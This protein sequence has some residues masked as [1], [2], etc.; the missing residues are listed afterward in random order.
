MYPLRRIPFWPWLVGGVILAGGLEGATAVESAATGQ[1]HQKIQPLL[2]QYCYQCHGDGAHKGN[3]AFD[4]LKSNDEILNHDLWSKVMVNI[5]AGLMPP[6]T[7][8]RPS[9]AEQKLLEDWVKHQAF[10]IDS[11]NPD[12]GRVTLRR[13]N[14]VQYQNTIHDL[15]GVDFNAGEEFPPDDTGYGF[16]DIGD[17]LTISPM[18]LE[19]YMAAATTIVNEGVP[20]VA[21]VISQTRMAGSRFQGPGYTPPARA[22]G[23]GGNPGPGDTF[24][25]IPFYKGGTVTN[26]FEVKHAGHYELALEVT[27]KGTFNFDPGKCRVVLKADGKELS[28]RDFT[29]ENT[30]TFPVMKFEQ[31]WEPGPHP[32]SFEVQPLTPADQQIQDLLEMRLDYVEVSGPSDERYLSRPKNFDRFFTRDAPE[33]PRARRLYARE[34]LGKFAYKAFRR[35]VDGQTVERLVRLAE[36]VYQLPGKTFE[37]G[38]GQAMVAVLA[39]P[40]FLFLNEEAD[41][42][43]AKETYPLVDEYALA[44][45][46]SYFLWCPMPDDD[47]LRLAATGGLR[48]H[49]ASQVTRML[50]DPR[51]EA[52]VNN[53]TGQWLQARD[54]ETMTID[55]RT[56]LARDKGTEKAPRG[57]GGNAGN[58][59]PAF[60]LNADTKQAMER[61]TQMVFSSIMHEDRSLTELLEGNYT[62]LNETLAKA[63]GLTNLNVN[64]KEMRRVVLPPDSARGGVLTEGT[65]LVVTSNPDR[66][67]PVKRG[68]FV[69]NN[70]LGSPP[71]PPPPNIPALEVAEKD[72]HDHPPTLRE[73]LA[74][75]RE[76]PECSACHSRMD[77]LGLAFENFNALGLWRDAERSQP[78]EAGGQLI[79]G[80]KFQSVRELKHILATNH[81]E[82]FYRTLA[83]K[84]MTFATGRGMEYYDTETVDQ[85]VDRM[86][87]EDGRFSALLTG[88]IESA[89]FQKERSQAN[90]T[91]SNPPQNSTPK[92][93]AANR[94]AKSAL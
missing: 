53:F 60:E 34:V 26:T 64:G 61:E 20:K 33:D 66:T 11:K 38:I 67:S 41:K 25:G 72:F 42:A 56:V 78:I 85:I 6:R 57:R 69:L 36:S 4:E 86:K 40:R 24:L 29:W 63:Y 73:T 22:R 81:R 12:P 13:L 87:E 30:R 59:K 2:E 31:T 75:H 18:L 45:R 65:F 21:K 91:L 80:E 84:M 19:K 49:L 15:M 48:S 47:L 28:S 14:R 1:F 52:M 35:R 93:A 94:T 23:G 46:L 8:P 43:T 16:D 17:V 55:A 3:V 44:S 27:V 58:A 39:S 92:S 89:P 79:T 62:F 7:E 74:L 9:P 71:P 32:L 37:E 5:R 83:G 70:I 77:P 82:E 50:A 68:L 76:S 54:I 90:P 51:A 88:I 10:G